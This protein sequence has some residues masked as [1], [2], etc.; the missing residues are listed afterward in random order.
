[1]RHLDALL[2]F[3]VAA[4]A[5]AL[6]TP[7]AAR[8]ARRVGA[9]ARPREGALALK[10]T[11]Q[12]GGLAIF[13]GVLLAAA[14]WMPEGREASVTRA[15]IAGAALITLVGAVDDVVNLPPL[16][17]LAGQVGAALVAVLVGDVQVFDITIPFLG[18]LHFAPWVGGVL[19]VIWLV[20]VMNAVNFIDG[21]DGLAAGLCAIDGV[22]FTIIVFE[23]RG[24]NSTLAGILAAITAGAA[25]GF[26]FHN[27]HPASIFM[28]DSGANLLGYLA[29]VVT[30]EG[31][32]KTNAAI[33]L[34]APLVILAV[35]FLDTGFV[36][37]KRLKYRRKPW[38]ADANH[39]H[40]RMA[41]IGFS[42]RKTVLYMYAWSALLAAFAVAERVVPW[43]RHG[44]YHL[45]WTILIAALGAL[46]LA[47]SVYVV[48]VLEIFKFK[49][50][51]ARDLRQAEPSTSEHEIEVRVQREVETGEFE[52]VG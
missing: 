5:V 44:H 8:L 43:H 37:A 20:G 40:H 39:F 41:R 2:A 30:I 23:L 28:G 19:T 21:V 27:F 16:L 25:L 29:G 42:Q 34:V 6:L 35:P 1:M 36:V 51:R 32:L 47:G 7:L 18:V 52:T 4:A 38:S 33:A 17:K 50:L 3:L 24:P 13:A 9:M 48:Y 45:G 10:D 11:P 15:I 14:I 49:R 31:T 26:L 22:A 46:A 12:L